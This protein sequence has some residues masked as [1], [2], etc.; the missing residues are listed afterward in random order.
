MTDEELEALGAGPRLFNLPRTLSFGNRPFLMLL[1]VIAGLASAPLLSE[2]RWLGAALV[3]GAVLSFPLFFA[4]LQ[5]AMELIG[6]RPLA[7]VH[8]KGI[9]WRSGWS[10]GFV[11]WP[12]LATIHRRERV[13]DGVPLISWELSERAKGVRPIVV[14]DVVNGEEVAACIAARLGKGAR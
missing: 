6:N 2:G 5:L 1:V 10:R 4:G 3:L 11:A 14:R 9:V 12:D 13:V 7:A 8:E